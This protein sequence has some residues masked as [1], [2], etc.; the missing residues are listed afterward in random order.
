L[1]SKA[2]AGLLGQSMIAVIFSPPQNRIAQLTADNARPP[3][4]TNRPDARVVGRDA[5]V[6]QSGFL[7]A[8]SSSLSSPCS[9]TETGL[10]ERAGRGLAETSGTQGRSGFALVSSPH[11][12]E[13]ASA[14]P[15][16]PPSAITFCFGTTSPRCWSCCSG[17]AAP[18]RSRALR[19]VGRASLCVQPEVRGRALSAVSF[20]GSVRAFS[21][22]SSGFPPPPLTAPPTSEALV[23]AACAGGAASPSCAPP[24]AS[25]AAMVAN[26]TF[27]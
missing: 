16:V 19:S 22:S 20:A 26:A 25:A 14:P 24:F 9:A 11:S 21:L 17:R 27:W 23:L 12:N 15:L 6:R 7:G 1:L 2:N 8:I 10:H 13:P 18:R 4:P 5:P 3:R